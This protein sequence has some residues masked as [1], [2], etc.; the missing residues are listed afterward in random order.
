MGAR[1]VVVIVV[2]SRSAPST[3]WDKGESAPGFASQLLQSSSVPIDRYSYESVELMKDLIQRWQTKRQLAVAQARLDGRTETEAEASV[4]DI[5]L[6][7][8]DV[9]FDSIPDPKERAYFMNLPT[10]FVLSDE[11]V[12]RLQDMGA[13]LLRTSPDYQRLVKDFGGTPK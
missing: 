5:A 1:R 13:L 11:S 9:S 2:N 10:S 7:A 6:Y 8:I 4:P 12:D 3:N